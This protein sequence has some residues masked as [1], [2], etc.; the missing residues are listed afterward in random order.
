MNYN[1]EILE[2]CKKADIDFDDL[3]KDVELTEEVRSK[4]SKE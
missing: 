2:I 1:D 3:K 4:L